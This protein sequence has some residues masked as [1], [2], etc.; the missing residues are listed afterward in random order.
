[1][2]IRV[3]NCH[4]QQYGESQGW[5]RDWEEEGK[6]NGRNWTTSVILSVNKKKIKENV[7]KPC[8]YSKKLIYTP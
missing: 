5:G 2:P 7:V 3:T 8:E 6:A 4:R 1:M